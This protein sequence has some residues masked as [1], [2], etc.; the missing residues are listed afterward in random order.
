MGCAAGKNRKT[1][2]TLKSEKI[3]FNGKL[4]PSFDVRRKRKDKKKKIVTLAVI[5]EV[6]S[7]LEYSVN[8]ERD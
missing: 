8:L 7:Q 2:D 5:H 3:L 4:R 6:G 1:V